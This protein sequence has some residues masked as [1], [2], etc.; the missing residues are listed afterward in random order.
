MSTSILEAVARGEIEDPAS[1]PLPTPAPIV[2]SKSALGIQPLTNA[3]VFAYEDTQSVLAGP[4]TDAEANDLAVD[5]IISLLAT[6]G[7]NFD[8]VGIWLNFDPGQ[9]LFEDAHYDSIENDVQ[10]LGLGLFNDRAAIG[11]PGENLEGLVVM[12][13]INTPTWSAGTGP[14]ADFTRMV[15]GHEFEH[16][17][18]VA[19][20]PLADGRV[21]QGDDATCGRNYHWNWRVDGQGSAMEV[22]E[23]VGSSPAV[24]LSHPASPPGFNLSYNTDI[25]GGLFSYADLYLMGV[26][27]PA[28]MDAGLSELRF[29]DHADCLGDYSGLMS[30]FTSA[31][32]EQTSGVRIPDSTSAQKDFRA[33]WIM[34]H[35]PGDPPDAAELSKAVGIMS[36]NQLD[37]SHST[38]GLS[39]IDHS[40][41]DD[42]NGND[43]PD[44][45]DIALATSNDVNLNGI[46]DECE[47]AGE[48]YCTAKVTSSGCVPTLTTSGQAS[49]TPVPPFLITA[50]Q[51]EPGNSGLLFYSQN[52]EASNV[53]Q[54]G[55]LCVAG[56]VQRTAS[57]SSGGSGLCG[58][59]YQFDFNAYVASDVDPTLVAGSTVNAQFW[60]RDPPE[61]ISGTGLSGG[62]RFLICP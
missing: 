36:Q 2:R 58:G 21:L 10:G 61:T 32:I 20:L 27:S 39:T 55:F 5:A 54:G 46:P 51:V 3:H 14:D 37:W 15:M 33:G 45:T 29:M 13:N 52:G 23:W 24:R 1:K 50:D 59:T 34:I 35:L 47:C 42:C 11:I 30:T 57:Q 60:F 40:L 18:G 9:P 44:T 19:L 8:F 43:V 53:F 4:F 49:A 38:L 56:P 12:W 31:D 25:P 62:V 22:G 41:F 26:V 48:V 16:R 6:H 7:D 28:E 17:F